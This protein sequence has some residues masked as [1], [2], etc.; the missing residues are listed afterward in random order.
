MADFNNEYGYNFKPYILVDEL[1]DTEI[2]VGI[3][4][5]GRSKSKP[6]WQIKKS[7]KNGSVWT[8]NEYPNGDQSFSFIWDNRLTYTYT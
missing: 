1:S 7:V 5:N 6:I 4:K 3:S 2:Y 8:I